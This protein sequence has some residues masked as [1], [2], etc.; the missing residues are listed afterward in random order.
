MRIAKYNYANARSEIFTCEMRVVKSVTFLR[1]GIIYT[2]GL[3]CT[4][5]KLYKS[6]QCKKFYKKY[7]AHK[8]L[9]KKMAVVQC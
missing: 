2:Y 6:V 3:S 4:F 9:Q 7:S 8:I 1:I 5:T